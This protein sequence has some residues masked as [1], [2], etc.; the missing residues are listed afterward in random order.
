MPSPEVAI[1]VDAETGAWVTDG[2]EMIYT[3]RAF[4]VN[5][6][7]A[8]EEAIGVEVYAKQLHKAAYDA[9]VPWC[10]IQAELHGLSGMEVFHHYLK[11]LSQRGWGRFSLIGAEAGATRVRLDHSAIAAG[12][13]NAAGRPVCYMFLGAFDAAMDWVAGNMG[14]EDAGRHVQTRETR[15]AANGHDHCLFEITPR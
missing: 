7:K 1:E 8:V 6:Q 2:V 14:N 15:C 12:F 10:A 5:I 13:G 9:T 3:P 4:F 11:R